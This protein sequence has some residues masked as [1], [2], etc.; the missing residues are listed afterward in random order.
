MRYQYPDGLREPN[1]GLNACC[2]EV[3]AVIPQQPYSYLITKL[4][5]L[6]IKILASIAIICFMNY[7]HNFYLFFSI[8]SY[9][10]PKISI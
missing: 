9:V 5:N 8:I 2:L 1:L 6:I 3:F 4:C 10:P 7:L